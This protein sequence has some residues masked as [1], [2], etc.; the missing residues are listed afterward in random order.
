MLNPYQVEYAICERHIQRVALLECDLVRQANLSRQERPC[1][2]E[3]LG[4]IQHRHGAAEFLSERARWPAKTTTNIEHPCS[5]VWRGEARE[6]ARSLNTSSMELINWGEIVERYSVAM[7]GSRAQGGQYCR[8]KISRLVGIVGGH[9]LC[10]CLLCHGSAPH[11]A[12]RLCSGR[13]AAVSFGLLP[14]GIG[15]RSDSR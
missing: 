8:A 9:E 13:S 10:V 5:R 6:R 14:L 12:S 1:P 3:R 4:Q 15:A 7:R 11:P 2:A